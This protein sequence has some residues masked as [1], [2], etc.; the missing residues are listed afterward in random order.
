MSKLSKTSRA[1]KQKKQAQLRE[2]M[3]DRRPPA[4]EPN[5]DAIVDKGRS[6][7]YL[8][9]P[10]VEPKR[11]T[12]EEF[13]QRKLAEIRQAQA[14]RSAQD[15]AKEVSNATIA[16]NQLIEEKEKMGKKDKEYKDHYGRPFNPL[17]PPRSKPGWKHYNP[18][19]QQPKKELLKTLPNGQWELLNKSAHSTPHHDTEVLLNTLNH[20]T[21]AQ[22]GPEHASH[23]IVD[24]AETGLNHQPGDV[25][26]Y[27]DH[28]DSHDPSH[29]GYKNRA[30]FE[31]LMDDH[32]KAIDSHMANKGYQRV[33]ENDGSGNGLHYGAKLYRKIG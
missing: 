19:R 23:E 24:P 13:K 8:P 1:E 2:G 7:R 17:V 29:L 15:R 18:P 14:S 12:V 33:D 22:Y 21:T 3:V 30:A 28:G 16:R 20:A 32:A 26:I 5:K 4:R 9:K 11:E 27:S 31:K 25:A 6:P 10:V